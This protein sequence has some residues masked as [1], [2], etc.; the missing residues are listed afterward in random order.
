MTYQW[1]DYE[2]LVKKEARK[3][4]TRLRASGCNV[5]LDDLVQEGA[6]TFIKACE[7]YCAQASDAKFSTYLARALQNNLRRWGKY[8]TRKVARSMDDEIGESGGTLHDLIGTD[9]TR[10]DSLVEQSRIAA[11]RLKALSPLARRCVEMLD[12]PPPALIEEYRRVV[13]FERYAEEMGF[14][15]KTSRLNLPFIYR[16]L[17]L[18]TKTAWRVSAEIQSFAKGE[19]Q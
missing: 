19:K 2:R 15:V 14:A 9:E 4:Y 18:P 11:A 5:E 17:G 6:I 3:A 1:C 7:K 8:E 16:A 10:P 12:S 13:Q